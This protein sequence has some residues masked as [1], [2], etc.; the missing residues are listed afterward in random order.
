M[1]YRSSRLGAGVS[2]AQSLPSLEMDL[3][4][5]AD[6]ASRLT[7]FVRY[8]LVVTSYG[9]WAGQWRK[10]PY[11]MTPVDYVNKPSSSKCA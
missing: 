6:L 4:Q 8:E 7:E 10:R 1:L 2:L 9:K 5:S 3:E 11:T